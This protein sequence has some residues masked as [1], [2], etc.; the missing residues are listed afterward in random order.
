[1]GQS[2][3]LI[4]TDLDRRII[5]GNKVMAARQSALAMTPKEVCAQ[6]WVNYLLQ[7]QAEDAN[8]LP[9]SRRPWPGRDANWRLRQQVRLSGRLRRAACHQCGGPLPI[10]TRLRLSSAAPAQ[11]GR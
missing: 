7:V 11:K 4:L 5:A 9:P 1:M 3:R 6:G 10:G 2:N 8:Q